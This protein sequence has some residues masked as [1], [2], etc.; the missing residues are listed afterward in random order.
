MY[1][2]LPARHLRLRSFG[3]AKDD[4]LYPDYRVA[5]DLY[6][7]VGRGFEVSAGF[8]RL[9]FTTMTDIYVGTLTKYI[10]SWMLTGKTMY[11]PDR[12][13]PKTRCR[14]T[15]W[16]GATSAARARASSASV[17]AAATAARS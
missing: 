9:A 1:P 5:A 16:C 8:R 10:G 3:F 12:Q 6:Q 13:G 15:A 11:V 2:E 14:S 17:T 4:V 7:S